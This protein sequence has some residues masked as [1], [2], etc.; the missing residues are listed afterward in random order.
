MLQLVGGRQ[1]VRSTEVVHFLE[2]P[3]S[4]VPLHMY[5]HN[6]KC[7]SFAG[8]LTESNNG[9]RGKK[10]KSEQQLEPTES[11]IHGHQVKGGEG[12]RKGGTEVGRKEGKGRE[13][14]REM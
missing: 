11:T 8:T 2:C 12:G 13:R 3:L 14:G 4:E 10:R 7:S 1:F 5:E 6:D 9:G